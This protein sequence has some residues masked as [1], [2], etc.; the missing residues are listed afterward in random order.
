MVY[1]GKLTFQSVRVKQLTIGK[2]EEDEKVPPLMGAA[3]DVKPAIKKTQ[4]IT[5][6]QKMIH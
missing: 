5:A 1:P 4:K 2:A 6:A 3:K